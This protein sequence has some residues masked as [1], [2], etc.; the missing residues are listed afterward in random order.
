MANRA[1][2]PDAGAA[3]G[4]RVVVRAVPAGAGALVEAD[5][6]LAAAEGRPAHRLELLGA[7]RGVDLHQGEGLQDVD[8]ADVGPG[9]AALVGQGPYDRAGLDVVAP[10]DLNP[11]D[12]AR[13]LLVATAP[14]GRPGLALEAVPTAPAAVLPVAPA[15]EGG[16]L[17]LN[18]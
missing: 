6:Q 5:A 17:S 10:A 12:G 14:A 2:S 13:A 15:L 8:P 4:G 3:P 11:V 9:D 1:K 7:E 18:K 16:E